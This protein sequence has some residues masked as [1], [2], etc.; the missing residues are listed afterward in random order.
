MECNCS[1]STGVI[2]WNISYRVLG[3]SNQSWIHVKTE[4]F[5]AVTNG[6]TTEYYGYTFTDNPDNSSRLT[7]YLNVSES[8]LIACQDG[9]YVRGNKTTIITDAGKPVLKVKHVTL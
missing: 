6:S 1:T 2:D 9:A 3:S 8:I 4:N 7:F 5:N